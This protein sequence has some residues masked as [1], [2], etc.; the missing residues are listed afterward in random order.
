MESDK[1]YYSISKVNALGVYDVLIIDKDDN[2]LVNFESRRKL[3]NSTLRY[4]NNYKDDVY[5]DNHGN[6]LKCTT[7]YLLY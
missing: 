5:E 4:F 3:S 1:I 2:R 7:H 6:R